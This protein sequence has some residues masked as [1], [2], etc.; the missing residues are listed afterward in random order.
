MTLKRLLD[1]TLSVLLLLGLSPILFILIIVGFFH[2]R[3]SIFFLQP[4]AGKNSQVFQILKFRTV[5]SSG[6]ISSFMSV[7]RLLGL[8]ELP[9]LV[10]VL[11]GEMS[12]VGPRPLLVE[13]LPKYNRFQARRHEVLPGITGWAQ[14]NGRNRLTWEEKFNLDVWYVDNRTF[15]LD[16]KILIL[17]FGCLF[18][19]LINWGDTQKSIPK[20]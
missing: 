4:R 19:E 12:L 13:Y 9:N 20:F 10:N 15:K 14:V 18:Q 1:I 6:K 11:K 17:T 5:S 7:I 8:D 16:I 3:S 2:F